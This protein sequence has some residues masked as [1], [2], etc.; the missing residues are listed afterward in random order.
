MNDDALPLPLD[1]NKENAPL[2]LLIPKKP[3]N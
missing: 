1:E 2:P 3:E